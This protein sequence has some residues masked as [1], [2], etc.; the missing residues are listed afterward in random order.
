MRFDEHGHLFPHQIIDLNL[1]D[2]EAFFVE[3]LPD[4]A[5]RRALFERYLSFVGD[6]KSTFRAPFF[7]WVDGSF[8]TTKELPGDIDVV[9]FL[10]YELMTSHIQAV[11]RFRET[12]KQQYR[13]D[14]KFSPLCKWNHRYYESAVEQEGYWKQLFGFSR[15]DDAAV[16]HPKGIVKLNFDL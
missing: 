7:Q 16:R 12:S 11:H 14:A 5:H 3:H 8:I 10:P 15:P 1:P 6:L 9:T 2:F 13:V 4:S